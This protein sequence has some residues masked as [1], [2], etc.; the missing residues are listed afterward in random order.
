MIPQVDPRRRFDA[1]REDIMRAI[2]GVFDR[3]RFMLGP[4]TEAFE[5]EFG[6][7][8]SAPYVVALSSGTEAI[9]IALSAAGLSTWR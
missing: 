3:G 7:A 8:S 4:E 9:A 5:A 1:V 6:E 2:I